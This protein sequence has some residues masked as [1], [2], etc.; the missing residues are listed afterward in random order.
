M[1]Q[2]MPLGAQAPAPPP[3][4]TL[5]DKLM[6]G[7]VAAKAAFDK[8]T[9][10][11]RRADQVRK[12]LQGLAEKSDQVTQEDVIEAAG[13][14]VAGGEDPLAMAGLLA[15]MPQEGG[16]QALAGWV[17]QHAQQAA[18]MEQQVMQAHRAVAHEVGTSAIHMM[19]AIGKG[20]GPG[21]ASA[22]TAPAPTLNPLGAPVNAG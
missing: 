8:T 16:G 12:V 7:H 14:L 19:Q 3:A 2:V 22:P 17:A 5:G 13:K 18:Q 10:A 1:G 15:D 21:G 6:P 20:Q 9:E 11:V 4:P